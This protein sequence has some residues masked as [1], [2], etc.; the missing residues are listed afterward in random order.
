MTDL[1]IP[2][3]SFESSFL[4]IPK[5]EV[6]ISPAL[7][8]SNELRR[9]SWLSARITDTV[10]DEEIIFLENDFLVL[11]REEIDLPPPITSI[12]ELMA[13]MSEKEAARPSWLS[14][15]KTKLAIAATAAS[16]GITFV[17]SPI[18]E[19]KDQLV[20]AAKWVV[21]SFAACEVFWIG[22][23]AMMLAAIG[24]KIKN[25]LQV[26]KLVPEIAEK[27][28]DSLLFRSG[29]WINS[30]AAVGQFGVLTAG[31]T[32]ELPARSWGLAAFGLVDLAV[33]IAVRRAI[34]KGIKNNVS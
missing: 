6:H 33:T 19:T 26:K 30:T 9:V 13:Q 15:Q 28:N 21:P 8:P 25:P 14:R 27:A 4:V 10:V 23:G 20:D 11:P 31:V 3:G 17:E 24:S 5:D 2:Q 34:R 7:D 1:A 32:T 22:G 29:F 16:V 18:S 12:D